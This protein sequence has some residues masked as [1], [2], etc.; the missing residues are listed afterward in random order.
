M[1]EDNQ[2]MRDLMDRNS[3]FAQLQD[4]SYE[5]LMQTNV[6]MRSDLTRAFENYIKLLQTSDQ[7]QR[8]NSDLR[9][10][11]TKLQDDKTT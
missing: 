3:N 2:Q 7:L 4:F 10:S 9:L 6:K 5:Q 11:L 1:S 8:H